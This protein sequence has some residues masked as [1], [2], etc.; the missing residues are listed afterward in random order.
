MK[1]SFGI[2]ILMDYMIM[3]V[4]VSL[5]KAWN[6]LVVVIKVQFNHYSNGIKERTR[7]EISDSKRWQFRGLLKSNKFSS[8]EQLLLD[9]SF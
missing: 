3:K 1:P 5:D 2:E 6:A 8:Q 4:R 9:V 7:V